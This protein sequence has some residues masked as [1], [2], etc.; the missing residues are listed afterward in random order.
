[1]NPLAPLT[2]PPNG[3]QRRTFPLVSGADQ[4]LCSFPEPKLTFCYL[5]SCIDRLGTRDLLGTL[6]SAAPAQ[7]DACTCSALLAPDPA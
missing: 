5:F 7:A 1:M 3:N 4:L 6:S 2:P